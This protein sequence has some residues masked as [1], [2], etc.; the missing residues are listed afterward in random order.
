MYID[1]MQ[2]LN[3][4]SQRR[5]CVCVCVSDAVLQCCAVCRCNEVAASV[6]VCQGVSV[7]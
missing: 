5:A 2:Q 3:R 4:S 7:S 6:S 1:F